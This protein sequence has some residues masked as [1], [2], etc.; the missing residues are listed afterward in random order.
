A[1]KLSNKKLNQLNYRF[2]VFN[3]THSCFYRC[4]KALIFRLGLLSIVAEWTGLSINLESN[5]S[6]GVT[7]R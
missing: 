5:T 1:A 7:G 3:F 4:K 2:A 6:P